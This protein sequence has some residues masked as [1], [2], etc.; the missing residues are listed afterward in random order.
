MRIEFLR[1]LYEA[2]QPKWPQ[3]Q[4]ISTLLTFPRCASQQREEGVDEVGAAARWENSA[5]K[6][7]W[8]SGRRESG[9]G[10]VRRGKRLSLPPGV[11]QGARGK[12]DGGLCCLGGGTTGND[13]IIRTSIWQE[14]NTAWAES[15]RG[16]RPDI[17]EN[18]NK[19]RSTR[20]K[21]RLHGVLHQ[22]IHLL[23][24]LKV[25]HLFL[26]EGI[27]QILSFEMFL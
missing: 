15:P 23:L 6:K 16:S 11:R 12:R 4:H 1:S 19:L 9:A 7:E 24:R 5:E 13:R 25:N 21:K 22:R 20:V 10:W 8:S 27:V 18:Y 2:S 14:I 3:S 26:P 17:V